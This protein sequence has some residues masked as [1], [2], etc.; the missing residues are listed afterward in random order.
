MAINYRPITPTSYI[1]FTKA[2]EAIWAKMNPSQRLDNTL[3]FIVDSA[4]DTIGKLYLGNTL[5][6][7]GGGLTSL[8]LGD[9][10]DVVYEAIQ[11]GDILM[12]DMVTGKW[13][14]TNFAKEVGDLIKVFKG[15]TETE[16]GL[17]GLVPQPISANGDLNKYLKGDGT[18]SNPTEVLE[19][20][21][22]NLQSQVT[23][24]IGDDVNLSVK[25]IA[26]DVAHQVARDYYDVILNKAPETLD[27][28]GEIAEWIQSHP[29]VDD[30]LEV[31][32]RVGV[33]ETS[34]EGLI[35][36]VNTLKTDLNNVTESLNGLK[37]NFDVLELNHNNLNA[38]VTQLQSSIADN[39]EDIEDILS[40]LMWQELFEEEEEEDI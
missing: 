12:Y 37:N 33:L 14:N 35:P 15:A 29:A 7:D 18:W 30:V 28:L 4:E 8:A 16:D 25:T 2:T 20:S 13:K 23:V 31:I 34:V 11:A 24:L 5:I 22:G 40:R 36:Q 32:N 38:L 10:S 1:A 21:V 9:L 3:Y 39:K 19:Q 6:A 27:T 26:T 17:A